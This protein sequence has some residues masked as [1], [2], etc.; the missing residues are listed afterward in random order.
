MNAT[1]T[2]SDGLILDTHPL[3]TPNNVLTN[4]LN[5]TLVTYNGNELI[6]QNDIGNSKIPSKTGDSVKLSDGFIPVGLKEFG[7]IMY[8]FS[9]NPKQTDSN[10]KYL[11]EIGTFPS[12]EY[13]KDENGN[14][15]SGTLVY[16]YKPLQNLN[17]SNFRTYQLNFDVNHPLTID[18]Q[19]SYDGSINLIFT[20]NKNI[21][22][23][24]NTRFSLFGDS[25]Y[26]IIDRSGNEDTNQYH[27]DSSFEYETS[28]HRIVNSIVGIQFNGIA[29]DGNLPI[30]NYTFYFTLADAD[31]NESD[32]VGQSSMV[33]CHKGNLNDPFSIDGGFENENSYKS[34]KFTL[35]NIPRQFSRVYV[36]Y[37]RSSSDNTGVAL[38]VYKKIDR[39]FSTT[40]NRNK[41]EAVIN[42]TGFEQTLDSSLTQINTNYLHIDAAKTQAMA[43]NILFYGNIKT[44]ERNW[45]TLQE[46]S[47]NE[48]K[49]NNEVIQTIGDVNSYFT[50]SGGNLSLRIDG[51]DVD[52][53]GGYYN[54]NNIYY[55]TGYWPTE[56]Y[57]FGIVYILD[58]YSLTPVFNIKGVVDGIENDYGIYRFS[59]TFNLNTTQALGIEFKIDETKL[60]DYV[61]GYFFVRQ[62]RLKTILC[63]AVRIGS[64]QKFSYLPLLYSDNIDNANVYEQIGEEV[65]WTFYKQYAL[66]PN[67]PPIVIYPGTVT[68]PQRIISGIDALRILDDSD[69]NIE[70]Q[71]EKEDGTAKTLEELMEQYENQLPNEYSSTTNIYEETTN[72]VNLGWFTQSIIDGRNSISIRSKNELFKY[73]NNVYVHNSKELWH[74]GEGIYNKFNKL[75]PTYISSTYIQELWNKIGNVPKNNGYNKQL[76]ELQPQADAAICPEYETNQ[77]YFNQL[78]TGGE[79]QYIKVGKYTTTFDGIILGTNLFTPYNSNTIY[80]SYIIGVPENTPAVR[81]KEKIYSSVA[82][83][84]ADGSKYKVPFTDYRLIYDCKGDAVVDGLDLK[85]Q[86]FNVTW[87]SRGIWSPYI[88]IEEKD[89]ASDPKCYDVI[90]ITL[91]N[92]DEITKNHSENAIITRKDDKSL[93]YSITK[94]IERTNSDRTISA[95]QGDCFV[96][97]FAHTMNRNFTDPSF[98]IN[99]DIIDS[100][101]WT[102]SSTAQFDKQNRKAKSGDTNNDRVNL[103]ERQDVSVDPT[104]APYLNRS[105]VNA[106]ALGHIFT[107]KIYS[108]TNLCMRSTDGSNIT[109]RAIFNQPRSFFPLRYNTKSISN[110]IA[111]SYT[112]NG[113]YEKSL[114]EQVYNLQEDVPYINSNYSNRIVYSNT[115]VDN[116]F[117]NNLRTFDGDVFQDYTR[118]Y[119]EIVKICNYLD[120]ILVVFEH[121]I[122]M[123]AVNEKAIATDS[124][125]GYSYIKTNLVISDTPKFLSE[126]YGS[127][128]A[129]SVIITDTGIYGIDTVAKKIWHVGT[130]F[131]CISDFKISKFLRDYLQISEQETKPDLTSLNI[132]SH[133]NKHKSDLMFTFFRKDKDIAWNICYN[134]ILKKFSTFYSWLP[135]YSGNINNT[136]YSFDYNNPNYL[137]EHNR[138]NNWCKWYGEQHPFEFEFI[139]ADNPQ[140]HKIFNDLKI[141]ANK[142]KPESFHFEIVGEVYNFKNDKANMYYRQER[143]KEVFANNNIDITYDKDYQYDIKPERNYKSTLFPLYISRVDHKN[144][145]YDTY[146]RMTSDSKDYQA[147]SG[148]EIVY[149]R[150]TNDF[151]IAT[152]IK[153]YPLDSYEWQTIVSKDDPNAQSVINY[154]RNHNIEVRLNPDNNEW[155]EKKVNY[156]RRLGNCLY[157]EDIWNVQIPSINFQEKNEKWVDKP[158]INL[159]TIP[160]AFKNKTVNVPADTEFYSWGNSKQARIRDKYIRIKV[161]YSGEDLAIVSAIIT[162]YKESYS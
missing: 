102:K 16:E 126:N 155:W 149:D 24:I 15:K 81:A 35:K 140:I 43:S 122:A 49:I 25:Q 154:Y 161:R 152:H 118:Q 125:S 22:R 11:S 93:Y 39:Y 117:K 14:Y 65:K 101:T 1:N 74:Y 115:Y 94:R 132:K 128:W 145:I 36:Y 31:D 82:G 72:N 131:E 46:F 80:D 52:I 10:G 67:Y 20:D 138:E 5:G 87:A 146:Q 27:D 32:F 153:A 33:T 64:D 23:L 116:D 50:K 156:G 89:N 106:V 90:N 19:K 77:A 91:P 38:T 111:D 84:P 121:A 160:E 142:T 40:S 76:Y 162:Q 158:P 100:K 123:L 17:D 148:S 34:V 127:Q 21:P 7:G 113:A 86:I 136:F 37:S 103:L 58:D 6:L 104:N 99:T 71:F 147:F 55:L 4:C 85:A 56:Y 109:E 2:F 61:K 53:N 75:C 60:P 119:G 144:K 9:V 120:D 133:F 48:V 12:P 134:T 137:W 143:M 18:C 112:L 8:I 124:T 62:K 114:G 139:C 110:K 97:P 47:K 108:S 151:N 44:R 95:F 29:S 57:R 54:T 107:T 70:I 105:D 159:A 42:I 59:N 69:Y 150:T 63:Q 129:D 83:D 26:E 92:Y 79:L 45:S 130:Q 98:P 157:K 13:I 141:I 78:F 66:T 135:L 51:Q 28:L 88:G 73:Y 41:K 96:C 68:Q 3:S 30:G